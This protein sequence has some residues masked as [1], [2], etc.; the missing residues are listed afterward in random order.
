[1]LNVLPDTWITIQNQIQLSDKE[2]ESLK[3]LFKNYVAGNLIYPR[4]IEKCVKRN[5]LD[6]YKILSILE[7]E[8]LVEKNYEYYCH[9]CGK[10]CGEIY[11]TIGDIPEEIYCEE[12]DSLLI[13]DKNAI[14][15]Y[16]VL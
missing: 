3:L 14:I 13:F 16:R 9:D 8:G 6:V 7:R 15:I 4:V 2:I 12:C 10:F 5:M 1:M 11:E